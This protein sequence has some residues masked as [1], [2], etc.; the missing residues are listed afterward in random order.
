[1]ILGP[2]HIVK[3]TVSPQKGSHQTFRNNFLKS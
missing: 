2:F 3:Y 1:M